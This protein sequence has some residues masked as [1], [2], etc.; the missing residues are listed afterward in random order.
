MNKPTLVMMVGLV[1]SG[2]ST[3]AKQFAEEMPATVFSS[4]ELREEMFGDVNNQENNQKLFQELHKRIKECLKSGKNAIYDATNIS[5]KRRRSFL[6][7]LKNID[8]CKECVI[9]ATPYEQCLENNKNRDRVVPEWAIKKMY[10]QWNTPYWFEGWDDIHI[11]YWGNSENSKDIHHYLRIISQYSQDNPHHTMTLG[12]HCRYTALL[13]ELD[14]HDNPN[15]MLFLSGLMHD[16]GKPFVKAFTDYKGD[17]V[18]IAHYYNHENTG[19]YEVLFFN[20]EGE[21]PL[22]ISILVNLH[23]RPYYFEHDNNEK[24]HNKYRKIWGEE[25]YNSVMALHEADK[26]AH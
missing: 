19:A 26:A 7:E 9:V 6:N 18:D 8:C 13:L 20:C 1:G 10:R 25:L 12:E 16:F 17:K 21:N 22:D 14:Y 23:M 11:V 4:D 5:S 24:L 3:Y 15:H 2:K